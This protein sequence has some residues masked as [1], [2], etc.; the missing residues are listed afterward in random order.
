MI[1][2]SVVVSTLVFFS[3]QENN[4]RVRLGEYDIRKPNET[5]ARDFAVKEITLHKEFDP[6]SYHNDI[7]ILTLEKQT[8]FDTY[9]WPICLPPVNESYVNK[10]VIVAGWGQQY[11]AGPTSEILLEV[12]VPVWEQERC[13]E[14]FAQ[15]ITENNLCAAGYEGGKDACLVGIKMSRTLCN[16]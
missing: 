2:P 7:A 11:Y 12:A 3:L 14:A 15:R 10:T 9:V 5:R 8:N 1:L 6:A 13:V 16:Y 4:L